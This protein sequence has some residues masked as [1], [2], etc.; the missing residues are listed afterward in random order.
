M[1][2]PKKV[3]KALRLL[4]NTDSVSI[5][6]LL[7]AFDI[8]AAWRVILLHRGNMPQQGGVVTGCQKRI[9][10]LL[11]DQNFRAKNRKQ[12]SKRG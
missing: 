9:N 11:N 8:Q 12:E 5:I 6:F 2:L 4:I 3:L 7:N 1:H 10:F